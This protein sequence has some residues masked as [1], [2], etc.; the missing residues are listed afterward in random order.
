MESNSVIFSFVTVR[1][2]SSSKGKTSL[3][4]NCSSSNKLFREEQTLLGMLSMPTELNGISKC[5]L[6]CE[7][8]FSIYSGAGKFCLAHG[9]RQLTHV[10]SDVRTLNFR[11]D[12]T[13]L[14]Q[15]KHRMTIGEGRYAT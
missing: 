14:H 5:F 13:Y 10:K 8:V 4:E 15:E 9:L 6:T 7:T 12:V 3:L 2:R 11:R 1:W